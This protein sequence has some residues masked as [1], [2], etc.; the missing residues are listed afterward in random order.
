MR[1]TGEGESSYQSHGDAVLDVAWRN[2]NTLCSVGRDRKIHVWSVKDAKKIAEFSGW[3]A[4]AP[5]LLVAKRKHFTTCFDRN[6]REHS[7][8]K[9]ELL[10][11]PQRPSRCGLRAREPQLKRAARHG[12]LRWRS[13][14]VEPQNRRVVAEVFCSA[15][16]AWRF[17]KSSLRRSE[18][19]RAF[20]QER[21][22]RSQPAARFTRKTK[23]ARKASAQVRSSAPFVPPLKRG[24][25]TARR[26]ILEGKKVEKRI[27]A[28]V[29]GNLLLRLHENSEE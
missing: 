26:A 7:I 12:Q 21:A 28:A 14:N 5:R 22:A 9:K 17:R 2:T 27:A 29:R 6:V 13:A 3:D 16:T 11:H 8:E 15:G 4:D 10:R 25:G 24:R 20:A 23:Q 19:D 18:H 1:R